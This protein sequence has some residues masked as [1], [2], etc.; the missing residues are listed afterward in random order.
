M[1]GDGVER[2]G[3]MEEKDSDRRGEG[4]KMGGY[5]EEIE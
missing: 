3:K 2:G 1:M 5:D 4:G